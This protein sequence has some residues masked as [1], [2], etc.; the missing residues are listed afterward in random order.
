MNTRQKMNNRKKLLK[1]RNG[2]QKKHEG[3]GNVTLKFKGSEWE[4]ISKVRV[5]THKLHSVLIFMT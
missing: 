2:Y 5:H 1:S 4:D 3:E